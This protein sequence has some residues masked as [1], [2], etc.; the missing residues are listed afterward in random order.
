[1]N[2][3][4]MMPSRGYIYDRDCVK[5]KTNLK[6]AYNI[7]D[8]F[9]YDSTLK[10]INFN[11]L[12]PLNIKTVNQKNIDR[13]NQEFDYCFLRGSNYIHPRMNWQNSISVLEKLKIPVIPIGIGAQAPKYG[14]IN[15]SNDTKKVLKLI[16]DKCNL[17]GVRGYY[18]AE[19]LSSL[20]IN[21]VEIIG[22][23]TLYRNNNPDLEIK[24]LPLN[25]VE[26]VGY[27]LRRGINVNSDDD[28][29]KY[30]KIQRDT[31]LALNKRFSLTIMAQEE[32]PEKQIFYRD[33]ELM[34]KAIA[35]LIY[36][37]WLENKSDEMLEI[38]F[39]QLFYSDSVADY[40]QLVRKLDLVTGFRLHGNLIALANETPA[41][42]C[43]YD[44]RTREF[45]DTYKIPHY[46]ADSG[47]EF[48]LEEYYRQDLFDRFNLTYQYRYKLTSQFLTSNG[49]SHKM[50]TKVPVN[51]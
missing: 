19:V 22:C 40:Q 9:V 8:L 37:K 29:K 34:P 25:E 33:D 49:I 30:L 17:V 6:T 41:I 23:P 46:D 42:Y 32:I 51:N 13:Y 24:L 48:I 26:A 39:N 50:K 7:G 27:T 35:N 16:A 21:N 10:L 4:V 43:S 31:I 38:Y 11:K 2:V 15:L 44:S 14:K 36:L 47:K 1:M 5:T 28:L 20:G 3:L 45:V 18:T 12:E